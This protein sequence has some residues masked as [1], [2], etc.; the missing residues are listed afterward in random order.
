MHFWRA[1]DRFLSQ[2]EARLPTPW[3]IGALAAEFRDRDV[4]RLSPFEARA[5]NMEEFH[6]QE[7][8]G[9]LLRFGRIPLT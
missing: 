5:W 8:Y 1:D 4:P 9:N 2:E 3:G 7:P 6:V